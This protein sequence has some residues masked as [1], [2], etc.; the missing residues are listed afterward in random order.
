MWPYVEAIQKDFA[1]RG[2]WCTLRYKNLP[3]QIHLIENDSQIAFA[4][5]TITLNV[6]TNDQ[7][8]FDFIYDQDVSN[9][10]YK[11][12]LN[13]NKTSV[14]FTIDPSAKEKDFISLIIKATTKDTFEVTR[15]KQIIL[16]IK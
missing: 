4:N 5:Q 2:A 11:L 15:Y 3:P 12:T 16:S 10:P 1:A 8:D 7:V 6:Q 9:Y 14:T 13:K